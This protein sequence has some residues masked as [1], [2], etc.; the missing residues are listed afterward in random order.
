MLR[1][2]NLNDYPGNSNLKA[3]ENST[4]T[5]ATMAVGIP[6]PSSNR[7]KTFKPRFENSEHVVVVRKLST[8]LRA[9]A[10]HGYSLYRMRVGLTS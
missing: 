5:A 6:G 8:H 10:N 1:T 3:K 4:A 7:N 2:A 9:G